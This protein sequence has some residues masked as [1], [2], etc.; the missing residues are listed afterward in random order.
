MQV[1]GEAEDQGAEDLGRPIQHVVERSCTGVE[2]GSVHTIELI[3]IEPVGG[4]EHR[5]QEDNERLRNDRLPQ[6]QELRLPC[7][8]FDKDDTR[9]VVANDVL[10]VSQRPRKPCTNGGENNEADVSPIGHCA[11]GSNMDVLT[12]WDLDMSDNRDWLALQD[13]RTRLPMT[14]PRL[15]IIQNT[16]M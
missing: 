13:E 11:V 16:E 5:E 6:T 3:S 9:A 4:E 2:H 8:V 7:R 10:R 15:K 14:P 1:E 12:K